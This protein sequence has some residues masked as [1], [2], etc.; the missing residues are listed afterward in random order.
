[1]TRF[2]NETG[3]EINLYDIDTFVKYSSWL[4]QKLLEPQLLT[5]IKT[6]FEHAQQKQWY[7]TY[8]AFDIHGT[9]SV[10]DYRKGEKKSTTEENKVIYYPFAMETLQLLTET[11]PDI[12]KIIS[13][14][15][16]PEELKIYTD[17]FKKDGI[18]FKYANENPEIADAKGSF[19]FYEK[20]FYY[21]VMFEDKA[22][23]NPHTDWEPIYNYL[24]AIPYRPDPTWSM[25]YKEEYHK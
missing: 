8:W 15:S 3:I 21:N 2:F 17:I 16:Y 23:F 18:L 10:P 11:R 22:G 20:K 12:I 7:E 25:K 24:K 14:S 9:I 4:E 13:S 1:M 19:G 5:W 6:M